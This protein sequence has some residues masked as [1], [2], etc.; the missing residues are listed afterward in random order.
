MLCSAVNA[1]VCLGRENFKH[2]NN[3][4][5]DIKTVRKVFVRVKKT[6]IHLKTAIIVWL[7]SLGTIRRGI[8]PLVVAPDCNKY[9]LRLFTSMKPL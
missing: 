7:F 4:F 2:E 8:A 5:S 3:A 1:R 9:V 6:P